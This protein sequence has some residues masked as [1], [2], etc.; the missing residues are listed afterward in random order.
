MAS[1]AAG[2]LV[3]FTLRDRIVRWGDKPAGCPARL[4]RPIER[5]GRYQPATVPG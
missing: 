3:M 5:D 2:L 1:D 4:G